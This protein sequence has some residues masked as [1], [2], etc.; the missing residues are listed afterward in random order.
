M[1]KTE[2]SVKLPEG[3][4]VKSVK[5]LNKKFITYTVNYESSFG[6]YYKRPVVTFTIDHTEM[7]TIKDF[8]EIYYK[9]DPVAQKTKHIIVT[10]LLSLVLVVFVLY[11]KIV[12]NWIL[13]E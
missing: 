2:V 11:A 9:E 7:T 12:N 6:T 5:E 10:S 4:K 8:V 13:L 3:A 1:D